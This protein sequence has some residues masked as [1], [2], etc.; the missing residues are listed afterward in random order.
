[1]NARIGN[2]RSGLFYLTIALDASGVC[3]CDSMKILIVPAR[4][5]P[6]ESGGG[7]YCKIQRPE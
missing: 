6:P 1:M 7:V 5:R 2:R 4:A 3:A